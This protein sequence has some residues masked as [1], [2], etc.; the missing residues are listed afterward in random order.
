MTPGQRATEGDSGPGV[1][2]GSGLIAGG[3]ITG[4]LLAAM[5]VRRWDQIYN[6]GARLPWGISES[7]IVAMLLY[8][9]F[10]AVPLY[11]VAR[12]GARAAE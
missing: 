2:F 12:K 10:L 3:A 6:V 8:V 1:L 9:A 5:S 7:V 11:R 4:V